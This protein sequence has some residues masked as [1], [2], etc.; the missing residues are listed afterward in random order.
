M[1]NIR[2]K[3]YL[4]FKHNPR[5]IT[6][7]A[8][9]LG[10][11]VFG[12]VVDFLR[13]NRACRIDSRSDLKN[14]L[15]VRSLIDVASLDLSTIDTGVA[16]YLCDMF[17]AHRFDLLGSGWKENSLPRDRALSLKTPERSDSLNQNE[18]WIKNVL[19]PNH[20]EK[21][22]KIWQK[23]DPQYNPIDWQADWKSGHR[24][25]AKLWSKDC[26]IA[27]SASVDIKMPWELSRLQH[28]LQLAMFSKILPNRATELTK[29]FKNQVLDFLTTNPPDMGVNW[30]CTM[31]VAIRAAN[32]LVAYDL[33]VQSNGNCILDAEFKEIFSN[34]IYDHGKFIFNNLEL[35][36]IRPNNHYLADVAGLLFIAAYIDG[37]KEVQ[38]WFRYAIQEMMSEVRNQIN[39]DGSNFEFSTSY[40]RLSGEIIVYSTALILGLESRRYNHVAN[41]YQKQKFP[42][43]FVERLR[44]MLSFSQE[45][46]K[47]SGNAI[48]VGDNDNG[49]FFRLSPSG[50]FMEYLEAKKKYLN[51]KDYEQS[52]H[53]FWDENSL[54]HRT[55]IDA[56]SALFDDASSHRRIS[57]PLE[58]SFV[59]ALSMGVCLTGSASSPRTNGSS[60]NKVK[61]PTHD[62]VHHHL[63]H[64]IFI[65]DSKQ[66]S[67]TQ[68]I[69]RRIFPYFG[70]IVI[71]SDR[72]FIS[73]CTGPLIGIKYGS[74]AHD[75]FGSFEL[76]VD[77]EDCNFDPGSY[78][79]TSDMKARNMFRSRHAHNGVLSDYFGEVWRDGIKGLF[80]FIDTST[81]GISMLSETTVEV[82]RIHKEVIVSRRFIIENDRVE[83]DDY[84]NKPLKERSEFQL[85]S[86]GYGKIVSNV[87]SQRG[88]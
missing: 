11:E 80:E 76:S 83:I 78:A 48:Q 54:D 69:S 60:R 56:A 16:N 82:Y 36:E 59:K 74:H 40:H 58:F 64:T 67:L 38:R 26:P 77:G 41:S 20:V 14:Q 35:N 49:R 52:E 87:R 19:S 31:D 47:P 70:L 9:K 30:A 53:L 71:R 44:G 51:L 23:V 66:K 33:F 21:S 73:I 81:F 8:G 28:L 22:L 32:L 17:I 50:Q 84:S 24:W 65:V 75:D 29:E 7:I 10:R 6:W 13:R 88:T 55:F 62:S 1:S 45:C 85:Y 2:T 79:Y 18:E 34:S 63:H 4:L 37:A 43:W 15:V 72:I 25:D 5:P 61:F 57:F 86:P 68:S 46:T 39:L 27:P 42:D 12:G 3:L